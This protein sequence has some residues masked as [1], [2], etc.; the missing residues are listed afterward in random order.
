MPIERKN[1]CTI[2][3]SQWHYQSFCPY[4]KKKPI[5]QRGKET[6]KYEAFRDDIAIPWLTNCFGYVC[7]VLDCQVTTNLDVDHKATRGAHHDKKYD[8]SN[9]RFVC[10]PH[11]RQITD[12][13]AFKY[14]RK[15]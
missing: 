9:L 6:L 11:H 5:S 10:R 14:K 13:V 15:L 7:S 12:G 3:G 4:K 1:L 2:C 8:L